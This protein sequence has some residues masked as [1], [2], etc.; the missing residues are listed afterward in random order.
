MSIEELKKEQNEGYKEKILK[1]KELFPEAFSDNKLNLEILKAEINQIDDEL[2]EDSLDEFYQLQWEGRNEARKLAFV[3]PE[4][5][6]KIIDGEGIQ[7]EQAKNVFIEGDNLEVL[8]ILQNSYKNRVKCIYID[9]PYNTGSDFIYKDDFKESLEKYLLRTG[10]TDEQGLLTSNPK[11]SGRFHAN[12]LS[13]MYPRL[14]LAHNLLSDDGVILVSIDENEQPNL[15]KL[16]DMIFGEENFVAEF[17]WQKKK[18]GGNDSIFV[19]VEHEYVVLY[20]KSVSKLQPFYEQYSDEYL[21]RYSEE[22]DLGRFYWDTFKRKSGKQYY[23][24]TCPDG[25]IL[26]Y[27]D[28]GN[29]ISWLRSQDRFNKDVEDGEI[30][31]VKKED[32]WSIHFKQRLPKGKKPRSILI[33]KGNTSSGSNELLELFGRNIFPNPKPVELIEYFISFLTKEDDI[34]LDFFAGSGTTAHAVFEANKKD[35]GKRKFI[36]IQIPEEIDDVEFSNIAEISKARIHKSIE[37]LNEEDGQV[38]RGFAVYKLTKTHLRKWSKYEGNDLSELNQ[39]LDLFTLAPFTDDA[40]EQDIVVEFMLNQGY[41]LD[42]N[43]KQ[44]GSLWIIA[45]NKLKLLPL[46][47][48]LEEELD[49]SLQQKLL[50]DYEKSTLICLDSALS[51]EQKIILSE[52]LNV[53]TI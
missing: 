12:W 48:F 45:H 30:R 46:L 52:R 36:L 20:A 33:D 39:N 24:I 44:E 10:Q 11:A 31:F 7:E 37:K 29:K 15:R 28:Y 3:P 26:E 51:N 42:S 41:P 17:I 49:E 23:P 2:V 4:G 38:D 32:G 8:R 25:T 6:L 22:D 5:T 43:I 13:M 34:I 9:P 40:D 21:K 50:S 16:M 27:D 1:L 14:K 19:A 53:K 35:D 18:G 47:I